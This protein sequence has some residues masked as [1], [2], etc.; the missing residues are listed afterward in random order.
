MDK[1]KTRPIP[2]CTPKAPDVSSIISSEKNRIPSSWETQW[3]VIPWKFP[4]DS[5]EKRRISRK[6]APR[7]HVK[8]VNLD[9]SCI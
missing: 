4:I 8:H 9:V 5:R 2:S 3:K 1:S 6:E 7:F